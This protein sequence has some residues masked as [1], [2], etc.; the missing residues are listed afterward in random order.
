MR[1]LFWFWVVP[2]SVLWGWIGL[3]YHDINFGTNTL[4]RANHD[5]VF[6]IY[7]HILGLPKEE[8]MG[9][10]VRVSIIDTVL[11]F[12]IFAWRRRKDIRAWWQAR[13]A[14][15]MPVQAEESSAPAE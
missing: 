13:K 6:A 12:A 9:M 1:Y 5:L 7:S 4:S 8:I 11:I 14:G 2:M 10:F 3:S 15:P